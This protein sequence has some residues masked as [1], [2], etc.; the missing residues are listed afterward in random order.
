[1][2]LTLKDIAQALGISI[3]TVS[4]A[5]K[6]Y[7]DVSP[8]TKA[9]VLEY[10]TQVNFKPNFQASYLRTQKTKLVGVILP[11]INHD[12]FNK[13]LKGIITAAETQD[14]NVLVLCSNESFEKE[15]EQIHD[16]LQRKV[17][18]IFLSIAKNTYRYEHLEAIKAANVP[19]V[20]F[21]RIAKLVNSIRVAIDD[22][23]AAFMATEHL[24]QQGCKNIAH[25]RGDL[26]PQMSIDRFLGYKRALEH[27][28]LPFHKE[29]AFICA[30]NSIENGKMNAEIL[31][32][33]APEIDGLFT[34]TDLAAVGAISYF[35]EQGRRIP[36]D[37]AVI[38]FSNWAI[39]PLVTPTLSSVEQN[40]YLMGLK[41]VELFFKA[42]E[43]SNENEEPPIYESAIIPSQL[44]I[45]D[46]SLRIKN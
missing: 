43:K 1:M 40:G 7:S 42:L 9:R 3:A 41:V 36:K 46:S 16:L 26:I 45:R 28:G 11:D 4:K 12:F 32:K 10:V 44:I 23:Q 25:F 18:G 22:Q 19:L 15:V 37:I 21:N 5:L 20:L 17:D 29:W 30:E 13:I 38:G 35:K 27:Y 39:A 2:N 24:I 33:S 8:K 14:Y 31:L 34:I 6:N